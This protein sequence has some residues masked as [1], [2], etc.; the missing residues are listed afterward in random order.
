[1]IPSA[2]DHYELGYPIPPNLKLKRSK[3]SVVCDTGCM[4]TA[5]PLTLAYKL[6]FS[7]KTMIPA[8]ATMNGAGKNDLGVVG[9]IVINFEINNGS[10]STKQLC[11]VC[12]EIDRVYLSF[13][14]LQGWNWSTEISQV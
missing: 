7:K 13:Q 2:A 11:Y 8:V 14:G 5:I 1:M 10:K 12:T 6:G 4:S 3:G 9:V